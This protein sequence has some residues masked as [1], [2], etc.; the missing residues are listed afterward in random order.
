MS[1]A[2][3][4][5][6]LHIASGD[7][8][9]G[10]EVQMYTLVTSLLALGTSITVILL[11]HGTLEYRLRNAGIDVVVL[12]ETKL[13]GFR[14]LLELIR[15]I[16]QKRPNVIHTH[17]HK[18]NILGSISALV[19]GNI[20]SLRTVHGVRKQ[21]H[22]RDIPQRIIN[23]LNRLTGCFLQKRIIAVSEDLASILAPW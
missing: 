16:R 20:P 12:D 23:L 4:P 18:E 13:S 8:W 7:L 14:I 17:R 22:F 1:S 11:N 5:K 10:A 3:P 15:V 6:A 9:A 21:P 19:T 2:H